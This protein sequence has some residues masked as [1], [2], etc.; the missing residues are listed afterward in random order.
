MWRSKDAKAT[1]KSA[2]APFVEAA[3]AKAA[4]WKWPA[5]RVRRCPDLA[6]AFASVAS[7]KFLG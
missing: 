5:G 4:I 1:G 6:V 2:L 3:M 7:R